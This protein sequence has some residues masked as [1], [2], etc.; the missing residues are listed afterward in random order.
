MK[1]VLH[2]ADGDI[3]FRG[4]GVGRF[5]HRPAQAAAADANLRVAILRDGMAEEEPI[6]C[7]V[8]SRENGL[9]VVD[10]LADD[11]W[12]LE[13]RETCVAFGRG[14]VLHFQFSQ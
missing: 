8:V 10:D 4:I 5:D 7:R 6:E 9:Q 2:F 11:V 13:S 12:Q 1:R 14:D 3:V